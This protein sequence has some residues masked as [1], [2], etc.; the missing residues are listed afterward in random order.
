MTQVWIPASSARAGTAVAGVVTA[1]A[2][3]ARAFRPTAGRPET[4]AT[5]SDGTLLKLCGIGPSA[6]A[7]AALTLVQAGATALASWGRAGGLDPE[8]RAGTIFLPS[9]VLSELGVRFPTSHGW[10]DRLGTA[11]AFH[12]PVTSGTLLTRAA[13]LDAIEAK[14]AA[15]EAT[16]AAAVDMESAAVADVAAAHGLPFIAVRVI[17]DTAGDALPSAVVSASRSGQ[18]RIDRLL[19]GLLRRPADLV[20]LLKLASR[21]RAAMHSLA[22]LAALRVL[23]PLAFVSQANAGCP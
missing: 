7:E 16:G 2:A 14:A 23:G 5:L 12:H 10:R 11:A 18:V 6:A 15:F 1:L 3:E 19:L 4:L 17:I 22:A 13:A 8:L 20:D 9:E 21:Y